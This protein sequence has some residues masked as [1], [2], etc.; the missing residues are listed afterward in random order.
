M[1]YA[2]SGLSDE[3]WILKLN[4]WAAKI[5]YVQHENQALE[6]KI[7]SKII[8]LCLLSKLLKSSQSVFPLIELSTGNSVLIL[9]NNNKSKMVWEKS[10][11]S[12]YLISTQAQHF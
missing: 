5:Q 9:F 3:R 1:A 2:Q 6:I 12:I 11:Q 7:T 10:M 8:F 4:A